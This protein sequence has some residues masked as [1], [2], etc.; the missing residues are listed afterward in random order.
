MHVN[1]FIRVLVCASTVALLLG[2]FSVPAAQ[3]AKKCPKFK[4]VAPNSPA[5]AAAEAPKQ[6]IAKVTDKHTAEAPLV[7]EYEHGPGL[8]NTATQEPIEDDTKF[9]N[10]QILS[11]AAAPALNIRQEWGTPSLSDMDLYLYDAAGEEVAVSGAAN[12]AP[13]PIPGQTGAMGYEE[14]LGFAAARCAGYTI[15]SRN[16]M[17]EG[18]AMTLRIWLSAPA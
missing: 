5:E 14:I 15:E 16:F 12:V 10:I 17:T 9:F 1:R 3:A 13:V 4:P 2:A 18:E 7:I 11:K 8:W 6:T